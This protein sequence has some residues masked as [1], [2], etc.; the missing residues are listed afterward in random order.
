MHGID[1]SSSNQLCFNVAC[2][3]QMLTRE[4]DIPKWLFYLIQTPKEPYLAEQKEDAVTNFMCQS[5]SIE[6][7]R[8]SYLFCLPHFKLWDTS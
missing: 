2:S 8:R 3:R 1:V 6:F 5:Y 4:S 7:I